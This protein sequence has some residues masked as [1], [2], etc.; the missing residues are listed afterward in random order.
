MYVQVSDARLL[1]QAEGYIELDLPQPARKALQLVGPESR[2]G[3]EWNF[4][5]AESYRAENLYDLALPHFEKAQQLKPDLIP[6]YISLG[7]CYKRADQLG[8]AIEA[9]HE[10]DRQCEKSENGDSHALVMYNLGCYYALAGQ[11]PE[12]LYWLGRA[13]GKEPEY[14][15]LIPEET[16]F[17][18]FREDPDFHHLAE[19]D[20]G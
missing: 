8:R 5:I 13:L 20:H 16:D 15:K 3:F 14:R 1:E 2:A 6:I 11:K 7:W 19:A 12:M 18:H 10:A 17:D 9:L 4:L